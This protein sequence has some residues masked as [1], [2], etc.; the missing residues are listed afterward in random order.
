MPKNARAKPAL[1][2]LRKDVKL[3]KPSEAVLL[4]QRKSADLRLAALN[5][6]EG[7]FP[8]MVEVNLELILFIPIPTFGQCADAS[9]PF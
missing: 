4:H 9:P 3:S 2:L 1:L 7:L 5:R 8:E 6:E